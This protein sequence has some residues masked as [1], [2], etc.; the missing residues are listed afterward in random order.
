M[1]TGHIRTN[2][3]ISYGLQS[4]ADNNFTLQYELPTLQPF[5]FATADLQEACVHYTAG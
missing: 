2:E 1:E 4:T 3:G 5:N